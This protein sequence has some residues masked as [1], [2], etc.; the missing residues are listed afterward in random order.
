MAHL[1]LVVQRMTIAVFETATL[2]GDQVARFEQA[3][4]I[5]LSRCA[6]YGLI[7]ARGATDENAV[8]LTSKGFQNEARHRAKGLVGAKSRLFDLLYQEL[9]KRRESAKLAE[10]AGTPGHLPPGAPTP[11][12]NQALVD[13]L[14]GLENRIKAQE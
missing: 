10:Q 14:K 13:R 4:R 2:Q 11:S 9:Q 3:L 1:P 8:T 12:R 6:E 5:A 7:G